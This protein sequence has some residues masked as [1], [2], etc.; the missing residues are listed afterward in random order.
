M[1]WLYTRL[2]AANS[3]SPQ[4]QDTGNE[5]EHTSPSSEGTALLSSARLSNSIQEFMSMFAP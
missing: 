3:F 1:G 4:A 2:V 5:E